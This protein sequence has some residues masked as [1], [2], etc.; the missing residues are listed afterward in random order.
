MDKLINLYPKEISYVDICNITLQLK[1][2]QDEFFTHNIGNKAMLYLVGRIVDYKH[3]SIGEAN[4]KE[5]TV[6]YILFDR[7]TGFKFNLDKDT[8]KALALKGDIMN[9]YISNKRIAIKG[10]SIYHLPKFRIWLEL[11][12]ENNEDTYV[13]LSNCKLLKK[14]MVMPSE[15]EQ[16]LL[17]PY[18][19]AYDI[20]YN[21]LASNVKLAGIKLNKQ[22]VPIEA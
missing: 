11:V 13:F 8:V 16:I 14:I 9:A 5:E 15:S 19:L 12:K 21:Q 6:G 4:H 3:T 7:Q 2:D 17:I 10:D 20:F 18:R 1:Q 22:G